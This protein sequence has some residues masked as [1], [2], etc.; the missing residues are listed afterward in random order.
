MRMSTT[1]CLAF[2][3][4]AFSSRH[5]AVNTPFYFVGGRASRALVI[6]KALPAGIRF[7]P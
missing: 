3:S 2:S 6:Q 7:L 1:K 4:W 5:L